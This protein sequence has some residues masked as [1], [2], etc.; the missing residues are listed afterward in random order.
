M[1]KA[2]RH[3]PRDMRFPRFLRDKELDPALKRAA[4]RWSVYKFP[5]RHKP[6]GTETGTM[7]RIAKKGDLTEDEY[8]TWKEE[9]RVLFTRSKKLGAY[10]SCDQHTSWTYEAG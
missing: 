7:R 4:L 1:V 5:V 9:F 8:R 10:G 3:L 6:S 2:E